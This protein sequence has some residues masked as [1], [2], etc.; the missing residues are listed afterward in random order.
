MKTPYAILIGMALIAAALLFRQPS[1][2]PAQAGGVKVK[3][4]DGFKCITNAGAGFEWD[5]MCFVLHENKVT[6][7]EFSNSK[8]WYGPEGVIPEQLNGG[9]HRSL[10]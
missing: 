9:N 1:I 8:E 10:T 3:Y 2:A 5:A 4:M 7:F 6:A